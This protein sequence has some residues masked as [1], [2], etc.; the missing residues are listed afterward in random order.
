MPHVPCAPFHV[1]PLRLTDNT[2]PSAPKQLPHAHTLPFPRAT[3]A[4]LGAPSSAISLGPM[5]GEPSAAA[6]EG[7]ATTA[8]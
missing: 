4:L 8:A 1:G 5:C 7:W 6:R 3:H 2:L